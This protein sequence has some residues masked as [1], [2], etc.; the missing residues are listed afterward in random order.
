VGTAA[1]HYRA[2]S[3]DVIARPS[4]PDIHPSRA[5]FRDAD[6]EQGSREEEGEEVQERRGA[7]SHIEQRG[8]SSQDLTEGEARD[9]W[10]HDRG[11]PVAD[12]AAA[13][14]DTAAQ[15]REVPVDGGPDR[16]DAA[17]NDHDEQVCLAADLQ[18]R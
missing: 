18:S 2:Y 14:G 8:Q 6:E 15:S 16:P 3:G 17:V 9:C 5:A 1:S 7:M 12:I 11:V 13:E 10:R 4:L